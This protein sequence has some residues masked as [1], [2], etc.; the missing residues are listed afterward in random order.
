[1]TMWCAWHVLSLM[2]LQHGPLRRDWVAPRLHGT[3]L[4]MVPKVTGTVTSAQLLQQQPSPATGGLPAS[5]SPGPSPATSGLSSQVGLLQPPGPSSPSPATSSPFPAS[6]VLLQP[7][8]APAASP[9]TSSPF[10]P[11]P[12]LPATSSPRPPATSG[13]SSQPSQHTPASSGRWP[14]S[15]HQRQRQ[16]SPA[17]SSGSAAMDN[18]ARLQIRRRDLQQAIDDVRRMEALL[19]VGE[20][21]GVSRWSNKMGKVR[22]RPASCHGRS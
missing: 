9:A 13:L 10:Q 15:S 1:M 6:P 14:L 8:A 7:P 22:G 19:P 16:P 17:T 3:T 18:A 12:V 21:R 5:P 20:P 11:A 2:M 4:L